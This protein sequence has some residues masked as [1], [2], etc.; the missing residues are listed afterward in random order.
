MPRQDAATPD[1]FTRFVL[2]AAALVAATV[3]L[4]LSGIQYRAEATLPVIV[5]ERPSDGAARRAAARDAD[6]TVRP[7][8]PSQDWHVAEL[9][10]RGEGHRWLR[11]SI[12]LEGE[13][14]DSGPDPERPPIVATWFTFPDGSRR[15][16][17][18]DPL[19]V[20][21][22]ERDE[23]SLVRV[24]P[25]PA[26]EVV[27]AVL[28]RAA[29]GDFAMS[30]IG[31]EVISLSAIYRA[32]VAVLGC[33]WAAL[34]LL[35]LRYALPR[36]RGPAP[37]V[38]IATAAFICAAAMFSSDFI[39]GVVRPLVSLAHG[40]RAGVSL[41]ATFKVGHAVAFALL[42]CSLLAVRHRLGLTMTQ[43]AVLVLA[44]AVASEAVQLH[45]PARTAQPM[46]LLI[47]ALGMLGGLALWWTG[48]R[49]RARRALRLASARGARRAT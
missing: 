15:S 47:D 35:A 45:L 32:A 1:S 5:V 46:D 36:L 21:V 4:G 9:P 40:T 14:V 16:V 6:G 29:R 26:T 31:I 12:L 25:E 38:P 48:R 13:I 44:L 3:V 22:F 41:V 20:G 34:A 18:L 2:L 42:T 28:P 49:L 17:S 39:E 8:R 23:R 27:A 24:W 37:L 30:G 10:S 43:V 7:E 11:L 19:D 33:G